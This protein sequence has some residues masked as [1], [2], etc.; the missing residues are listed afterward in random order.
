VNAA[1]A[2][3]L[4]PATVA[5]GGHPRIPW[6][7]LATS[8]TVWCL[9]GQ[10]AAMSY[11]WYF[12]VTWFPTYLLEARGFDLKQS[13]LLA[14]TPLLLGGFGALVGGWLTP[15][16][17]RRLGL[18]PARRLLGVVGMA[19]AAVF[20][21]ASTWATNPYVAVALIAL[22]SFCMDLTLPG[23]WTSCMDIGGRA[24]G[25]LGGTM[26]M[27]GNLGGF[28]SPIV[29]GMIVGR[30]GNWAATF[31]VTAIVCLVGAAFW[32]LIDPVTPLEGTAEVAADES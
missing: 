29:L 13:A 21:V 6:G 4:P 19:L 8:R 15:P 5:D 17:A 1:E 18:G 32:L 14:G 3:L 11:A 23:S 27:M 9:C 31:H 26:N 7:R 12:F 10:Y 30:T 25:T 24:V 22:V 16:L 20:L 2:A 28:L